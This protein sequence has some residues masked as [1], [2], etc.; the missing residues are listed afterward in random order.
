MEPHRHLQDQ[1]ERAE[2][3]GEELRQVVPRDVLDHLA[4]RLRH[5]AIGQGHAHA[6]HEVARRA[7]AVAQWTRIAGRD[8]PADRRGAVVAE[9]RIESK[10][11]ADKHH[12]IHHRRRV[13]TGQEL[14]ARIEHAHTQEGLG[15][16]PPE[17][18]AL[19]LPA[20]ISKSAHEIFR[21]YFFFTGQSN[22][23]ALSRL[24]LSGQLFNGAKRCCPRPAPPRPSPVRYVPAACHAMRIINGP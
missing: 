16:L 21:P 6:K 7:V 15:G 20:K 1:P 4:A 13:D 2:G 11:L 19:T 17:R 24:A 23:R 10:H 3:S 14:R 18:R 12:G 22:R 5:G 8:H 9:G